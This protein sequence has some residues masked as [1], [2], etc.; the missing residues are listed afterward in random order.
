MI[1]QMSDDKP[2]YAARLFSHS[3]SAA[4]LAQIHKIVRPDVKALGLKGIKHESPHG[5]IHCGR[6]NLDG[7]LDRIGPL[8]LL[9]TSLLYQFCT[10]PPPPISAGGAP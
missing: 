6:G 10:E 5:H 3:A 2:D 4:I 8:A 7:M 9:L 1:L